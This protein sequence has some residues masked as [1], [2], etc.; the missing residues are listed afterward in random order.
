MRLRM[1]QLEALSR[2]AENGSMTRAAEELGISQPAVSRLLSDLSNQLGFRLFQRR[3][4]GLVPTQEVRFLL[5][6]IERL[7]DR[8]DHIGE[9]SRNLTERKAGHLKIACLPGFATSHLPGVL[10]EFLGERPGITVT[11]EPDRPERILE[12]MVGEQYDLGITDGF[13]GHPAV[14]SETIELRCVCIFPSGHPF[15]NKSTIEVADLEGQKLIHTRRDSQFYRD[16][17]EIMQAHG[18]TMNSFIEVRQFTAA[19]EFVAKGL[20]VSIVSELD[21]VGYCG[22]GVEFKPF[23]PALYHRLSLVRPTH[24]DPSLI[25]IEFLEKFRESLQ[26]FVRD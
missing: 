3:D 6:D 2:V 9:L 15:G 13:E 10:D 12:W 21:A 5:P 18:T 1:R 8:L 16:L 7:L 25:M 4:G 24:K 20:G 22:R 17:H 23:N 26:E 11:I 14:H 19:C